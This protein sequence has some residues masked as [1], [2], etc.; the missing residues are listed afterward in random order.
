LIWDNEAGIGRRNK[1][2]KPAAFF[3]GSLATRFVQLKPR[4]P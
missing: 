4:D 3:A 2:T 1:L